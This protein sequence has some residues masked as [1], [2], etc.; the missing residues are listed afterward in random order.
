[1]SVGLWRWSCLGLSVQGC[2]E[3]N[4]HP[5][6]AFLDLCPTLFCHRGLSYVLA[7]GWPSLYVRPVL[8]V[9]TTWPPALYQLTGSGP[10]PALRTSWT[11]HGQ[12]SLPDTEPAIGCNHLVQASCCLGPGA[13]TKICSYGHLEPSCE[14]GGHGVSPLP[15]RPMFMTY[16]SLCRHCEK[17]THPAPCGA[18]QALAQGVCRCLGV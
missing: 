14:G 5:C 1:M 15:E 8:A 10:G 12:C 11:P 4:L 7:L 2:L 16:P 6:C 3:P 17:H 9:S 18:G 13:D